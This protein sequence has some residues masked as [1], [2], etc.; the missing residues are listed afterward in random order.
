MRFYDIPG[1]RAEEVGEFF[2][3]CENKINFK[4]SLIGGI[5]RCIQMLRWGYLRV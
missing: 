3:V 1:E 5:D 4:N 2:A